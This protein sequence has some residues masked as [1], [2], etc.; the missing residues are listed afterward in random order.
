M[1]L[2][3]KKG[4]R[5]LQKDPVDC[6][7]CSLPDNVR[8]APA[9]LVRSQCSVCAGGA[10]GVVSYRAAP[11]LAPAALA[12]SAAAVSV[13]AQTPSL[14]RVFANVTALPTERAGVLYLHHRP[15][16]LESAE[17]CRR[18]HIRVLPLLR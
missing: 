10:R 13:D 9:V 5:V 14:N 11:F 3:E 12:A 16:A 6:F 18:S 2:Q 4:R 17:I 8:P 7:A 1:F 15:S